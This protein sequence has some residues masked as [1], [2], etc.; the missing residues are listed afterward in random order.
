[1]GGSVVENPPGHAGETSLIPGLG[2]FPHV[3]GQGSP[4]ATTTEPVL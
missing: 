1:M 4:N 2:G 3:S